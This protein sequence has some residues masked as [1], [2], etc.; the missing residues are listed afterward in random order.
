MP[1]FGSMGHTVSEIR[2][3]LYWKTSFF[4]SKMSQFGPEN[5]NTDHFVKK[6]VDRQLS[7]RQ[8]DHRRPKPIF[9]SS[10]RDGYYR[11]S[12]PKISSRCGLIV[13]ETLTDDHSVADTDSDGYLCLLRARKH[14]EIPTTCLNFNR[15]VIESITSIDNIDGLSPKQDDKWLHTSWSSRH[16]LFGFFSFF[17]L[18][19]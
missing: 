13:A 3:F 8:L 12:K 15:Y 11:K 10:I 19:L 1:D 7:F 2:S 16:A 5:V 4:S 6:A 18:L 14:W 9:D 17:F